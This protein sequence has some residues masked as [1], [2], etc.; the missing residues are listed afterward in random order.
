M[1]KNSKPEPVPTSD[2]QSVPEP[3]KTYLALR[4]LVFRLVPAEIDLS[5]SPAYPN[6]WGV[7][8]ETGYTVGT[9]T[10]VCLVD[11]TT[12]LYFSTGGGMLGSGTSPTLAKAA[13]LFVSHA[14]PV[15]QDLTPAA[16]IPS[17]FPIPLPLVG[18]VQFFILSYRGVYSEVAS[19][20]EA[21]AG[22]HKL[23]ALYASGQQVLIQ[24]RQVQECKK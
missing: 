24:L 7:V 4:K 23:S 14:E 22:Q 19:E 17:E 12:S 1:S 13:K 6:V 8:M 2:G 15:I 9:A 21:R 3:D 10:L 20:T 11:G 18:M 16:V 5:P